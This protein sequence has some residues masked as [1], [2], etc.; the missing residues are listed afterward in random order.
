MAGTLDQESH[1]QGHLQQPDPLAAG[2]LGDIPTV[3]RA[4]DDAGVAADSAKKP[5]LR[6]EKMTMQSPAA[7]ER[8]ANVED[9]DL[10]MDDFNASVARQHAEFDGAGTPEPAALDDSVSAAS[11][12][13]ESP[14]YG[15]VTGPP[16]A[17]PQLRMSIT[18]KN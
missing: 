15:A 6:F 9:A 12:G 7:G 18:E 11:V 2:V 14:G 1:A 17:S 16:T 8:H 13:M 4:H 10:H 5:M 3:S